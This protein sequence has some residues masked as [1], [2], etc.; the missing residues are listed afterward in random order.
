VP[1]FPLPT[2]IDLTKVDIRSIVPH[3]LRDARLPEVDA[4]R[5]VAVAKDAGYT[6]VGAAVLAFQRAQVKRREIESWVA[7]HAPQASDAVV[8]AGDLAEQVVAAVSKAV[9]RESPQN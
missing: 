9:R 1:S 8:R 7:S 3:Q 5:I 4:D 6:A 2:R